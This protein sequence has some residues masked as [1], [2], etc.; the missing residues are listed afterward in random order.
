MPQR[1]GFLFFDEEI[2]TKITLYQALNELHIHRV[3]SQPKSEE[4]LI[5][6]ILSKD[7][8]GVQV[9][10]RWHVFLDSLEHFILN[11]NSDNTEKHH[12]KL[13]A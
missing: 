2:R 4:W 10:N 12:Q 3:F 8:E 9:G 7:I 6:R 5:N 1:Q 11:I 13:A